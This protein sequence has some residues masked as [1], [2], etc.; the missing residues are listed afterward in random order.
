MP[1]GSPL[2]T[3]IDASLSGLADVD[4]VV[5]VVDEPGN[6]DALQDTGSQEEG[7]PGQLALVQVNVLVI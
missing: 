4:A 2:A 1:K 5:G 6:D 3:P 7:R